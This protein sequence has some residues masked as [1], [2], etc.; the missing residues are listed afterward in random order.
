MQIYAPQCYLEAKFCVPNDE[1]CKE[2]VWTLERVEIT[3]DDGG[4]A[5]K[6]I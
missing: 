6:R 1:D 3:S 2:L 5:V 4:G